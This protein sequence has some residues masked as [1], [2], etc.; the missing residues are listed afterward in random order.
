MWCDARL[1]NGISLSCT[2]AFHAEEAGMKMGAMLVELWC[3]EDAARL[4][5]C[6][7]SNVSK[8]WVGLWSRIKRQDDCFMAR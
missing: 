4:Q 2:A 8:L 3:M 6:N 5:R 1:A 7:G